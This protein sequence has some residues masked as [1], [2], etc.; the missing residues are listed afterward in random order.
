MIIQTQNDQLMAMSAERYGMSN[1]ADARLA[2][3]PLVR[4]L[5]RLEWSGTYS[6]CTGW[7]CCPVCKGIKPGHGKDRDTGELPDNTGHRATCE[8]GAALYFDA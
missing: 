7:A 2:F 6:Y 5:R 1:E 8:L 4:L 3:E